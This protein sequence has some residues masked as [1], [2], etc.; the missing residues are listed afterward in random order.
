MLCEHA[1]GVVR[2][3]NTVLGRRA[4]DITELALKIGTVY[5]QQL[6]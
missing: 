3:V 4:I 5:A 6:V 2:N 1:Q